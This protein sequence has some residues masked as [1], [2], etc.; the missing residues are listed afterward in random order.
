MR[1]TMRV[2]MGQDAVNSQCMGALRHGHKSGRTPWADVVPVLVLPP[3]LV[4]G[5]R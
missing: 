1:E 3:V 4:A 5:G 2:N